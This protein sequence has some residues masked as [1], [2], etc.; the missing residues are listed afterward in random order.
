MNDIDEHFLSMELQGSSPEYDD[1][2]RINATILM[3]AVVG[4]INKHFA[5]HDAEWFTKQID[6]LVILFQLSSKVTDFKDLWPV[7][8][9]GYRFYTNRSANYDVMRRF[10]AVFFSEVQS[11]DAVQVLK[12]L[13]EAFENFQTV[14]NCKMVQ[15]LTCLYSFLLT[16]GYLRFAGIELNDEDYSKAEQRALLSA[17]SSKKAFLINVIDITLFICERALE[18]KMTGDFSAFTHSGD[19]Y[20]TWLKEADRLLALAPFVGN[21]SAHGT[22]YFS[23]LGD[24]NDAIERGEAYAK[25]ARCSGGPSDNV[26]SRKLYSLQLLKNTEITRKAAQQERPSPMGV[27]V[28]GHSSVAKSSFTKILFNYFGGLFDLERDDQYRYVRNPMDE[29]WSNFD[30]SKWCIQLDDIAFLNPAKTNDTDSTL[31]DLLNVVNNVPYVPPQAALEDKGKTPVLARLVIATSN[32]KDLHAQEYFWCPLAVRRRLPFVIHVQPKPEF[33]HENNVFIDPLKLETFDGFFP[34]WWDI[35]VFEVVPLLTGNRERAT[36]KSVAVFTETASFLQYFGRAC[37][38]HEENQ[39]KAMSTD[40]DIRR[41]RICKS[42]LRPEEGEHFCTEILPQMHVQSRCSNIVVETFKNLLVWFFQI[43]YMFLA[44]CWMS[45]FTALRSI[46][47]RFVCRVSTDEQQAW[48]FGNINDV[49]KSPRLHKII[50]CLAILSAFLGVYMHIKKDKKEK[51]S[52]QPDLAVQGN[53]HGTTEKDLPTSERGNVWYNED[54]R[55]T[56]FDLPPSSLGLANATPNDVR[57]L[58][59][60]N[61]VLVH[62]RW[63]G[64]IEKRV[65]RGLFIKGHYLLMNGHA[66]AGDH[67]YFTIRIFQES[68]GQTFGPNI[69]VDLKKSDIYFSTKSEFCL[70]EI[71]SVPPFKDIT[72]YWAD[73]RI[74]VSSGVELIREDQG[75]ITIN[76][77]FGVVSIDALEIHELDNRRFDVYY[78]H[79]QLPTRSGTCG[80]IAIGITPRGP[81]ILGI[82]LLGSGDK[83]G[84]LKIW[85]SELDEALRSD[86]FFKRPTVQGGGSPRLEIQGRVIPIVE[87]HYKSM[88]RFMKDGTANLYGALAIPRVQPKSKVCFTPLKDTFVEHYGSKVMYGK[89]IM[90]GWEPWRRNV[91]EMV[92]PKCNYD[93]SILNHC[94]QSYTADIL[95]SLPPNWERELVFLS[96]RASINGLPGVRYIDRINCSSSMGFPWNC[97]KKRYLHDQKDEIYPEGVNFGPE[98][99]ERVALIEERYTEGRRAYPVFSGHLKDEPVSLEKIKMCKTRLFTGAPIDWS[100]VVRK[101]LLS[102]VRLVQCNKY[103]F[104]AAPGMV[105]QS[106]EWDTLYRYLTA[107]GEGRIVAGDYGKFDKRMIS[108]FVL[109]AFEVIVNVYRKAGFDEV[110][111]RTIM[112]IGEDTAFPLTNVNGDLVEFYGTN[113]SGHP[114]T[115][116]INSLVNALYMRYCYTHLSPSK[117][118]QNFRSNVNLMTYGDDNVMGVSETVPWF[119]HTSIKLVLESIGVEYT[120]ADKGAQ[121]VPYINISEVSFLKRRWRWDAGLRAWMAPLEEDSIIKSLTIWVPSSSIDQYLQMVQ[122]I[123]S[124]NSEYFFYGREVFNKKRDFFVKVLAQEPYKF[125]VTESTLPSYDQLAERFYEAS[126]GL[127]YETPNCDGVKPPDRS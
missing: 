45:R 10:Q 122:V 37:L 44:L 69:S 53:R 31:K 34:D 56:T 22:S 96:D 11:D 42:C 108:D 115:V 64:S 59:G 106:M 125:Y 57:D 114:L 75:T 13:R 1:A 74:P 78:A 35:E 24:L 16:Q 51:V 121:S 67:N 23:F 93:R 119:N 14:S 104:E 20:T 30:T 61:C 50:G 43:K 39:R 71:P 72:K 89:P 5:H 48:Y 77:F 100:I 18:Y 21:L 8:Q 103:A 62:I 12:H 81:V 79:G 6:N 4:L 83:I 29:F 15:K 41:I 118:C 86:K 120:M 101:K 110:E 82:H 85:K 9:T 124:A 17:Y 94:V 116:I 47:S 7:I 111:L 99:W 27:L 113:P 3:R 123:S 112:C 109:A 91:V 88:F 28:F 52:D 97:T 127:G 55:L 38:Q 66:F 117:S 92:K 2:S 107:H 95:A 65:M 105:V 102:F 36:L 33:K 70:L 73:S 76:S 60:R 49:M 68:V 126:W 90:S 84:F 46:V 87:P 80:S 63:P 40:H 54:I 32:S 98:V 26:I 19:L 25:Y 58:F